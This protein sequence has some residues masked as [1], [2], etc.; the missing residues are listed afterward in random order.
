MFA[1]DIASAVDK[2]EVKKVK[3]SWLVHH[4]LHDQFVVYIAG[5]QN[6]VTECYNGTIQNRRISGIVK[7]QVPVE[8]HVY[9]EEFELRPSSSTT[10][11]L[12]II[13]EVNLDQLVA[14]EV[15]QDTVTPAVDNILHRIQVGSAAD[16]TVEEKRLWDQIIPHP[17]LSWTVV[18]LGIVLAL[19]AITFF[20]FLYIKYRK[21]V[22]PVAAQQQ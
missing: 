18:V 1:N 21:N 19:G 16:M 22:I 20:C 8:C 10:M 4:I 11:K 7:V 12:T 14:P 9:T 15:R 5:D 6:L 2:C 13:K 3:E 17:I